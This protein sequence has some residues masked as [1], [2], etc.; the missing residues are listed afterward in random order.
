MF[1]QGLHWISLEFE[2]VF[3]LFMGILNCSQQKIDGQN[4][5]TSL[6]LMYSIAGTYVYVNTYIYIIYVIF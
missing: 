3:V 4:H 1:K 2:N 5:E 6:Q